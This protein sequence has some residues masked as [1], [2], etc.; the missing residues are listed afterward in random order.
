MNSTETDQIKTK[1]TKTTTVEKWKDGTSKLKSQE[2][3]NL[4]NNQTVDKW[5]DG[6]FNLKSQELRNLN[7]YQTVDKWKDGTS[8]LKSKELGNLITIKPLINEKT[9]LQS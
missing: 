5:K 3:V 4:N 7:N 1:T 6:T 9:E 8:K 2:F